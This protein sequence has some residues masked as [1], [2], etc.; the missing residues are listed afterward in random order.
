GVSGSDLGAEAERVVV[1]VGWWGWGEVV[2]VPE[3]LLDGVTAVSGSGPGYVALLME[4]MMDGAVQVG[5]PREVARQLVLA[6]FRGTAELCAAQFASPALLKD[7]V[8]SPGGTTIA[9]LAELEKGAVRGALMA[10]I[11][12]A[13]ERARVLGQ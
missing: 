3:A 4:A 2:A 1:V 10:A 7:Q 9:G 6:T 8:T 5:L 12:A 13:Y 11:R